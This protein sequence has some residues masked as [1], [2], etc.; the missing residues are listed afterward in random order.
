MGSSAALIITSAGIAAGVFAQQEAARR[1]RRQRQQVAT[2]P[3]RHPSRPGRRMTPAQRA[4]QRFEDSAARVVRFEAEEELRQLRRERAMQARPMTATE[5]IERQREFARHHINH[6]INE[7]FVEQFAA[8]VRAAL[9]LQPVPEPEPV[10]EAAGA[11]NPTIVP[12]RADCDTGIGMAAPAREHLQGLPPAMLQ[13]IPEELL[14]HIELRPGQVF[15]YR[16]EQITFRPAVSNDDALAAE[17]RAKVLLLDS[18]NEEQ[19]EYW[20]K[21]NYLMAQG[22]VTRMWYKIKPGREGNIEDGKGHGYC[23]TAQGFLPMSDIV[24]SQKLLIEGDENTFL[25]TARKSQ[26]TVTRLRAFDRLHLR[27]GGVQRFNITGE[28]GDG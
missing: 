28:E 4:C 22:N 8:E 5:V 2:M 10:N 20:L 13:D 6:R 23:I 18:L 16:G 26:R 17:K 25:A 24:L 3:D 27:A 12:N 11:N 19:K 9:G 7:V 21:K 15:Y 1:A 14:R